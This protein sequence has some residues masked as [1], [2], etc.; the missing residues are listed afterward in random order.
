MIDNKNLP[1][2]NL[3]IELSILATCFIAGGEALSEVVDLVESEY[4][5]RKS[6]K[7]IFQAILDVAHNAESA[8]LATVVES[9]RSLGKLDEVGGVEAMSGILDNPIAVDIPY[10]C[11]KLEE[12]FLLRRAIEKCYST[13]KQCHNEY[14]DFDNIITKYVEHAH[15]ISDG[16]KAGDPVSTMK[17][18]S[19]RASDIYEKRYRDKKIVTGIPTGI[20][21]LDMKIF[22]LHEGDLTILAARPAMGKTAIAL[23]IAKHAAEE[24]YGSLFMSLEMPDTQLFDRLVAMETGING[25][26]IRI[27]N[28][29][30]K[31]FEMVNNATER[32]YNLPMFIDDRGGLKFTELVK[33]VRRMIKTN[34]E[35]KLLIIDHLQLLLGDN[36]TNRNLE[37]GTFSAGLKALAKELRIPVVALSQ[38]NRGLE[39]RSNPYRR[40]RLSDLRDSGSLEQ[41]ADNVIFIYRPWEYGDNI[42]PLDGKTEV[43][44]TETDCELIVAKQRQGPT[45]TVNCNF[46][47]DSQRVVG[48]SVQSPDE[49]YR[50]ELKKRE[51]GNDQDRKDI[52]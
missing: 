11:K 6:H 38:L 52:N 12:K 28:F 19:V 45:G 48:L 39:N 5:Y 41:D 31:E 18:I 15:E 17:E 25:M 30:V 3:E 50:Q 8:D 7:I 37:V 2:H 1:P 49:L 36:P 35:I 9:L 26:N 51:R 20:N 29:T 34:P 40:P 13:I 23:N 33:T 14:G 44:I 43:Q 27:G 32:L 46:Y 42:S 47:A 10:S 22:G 16:A 24:G 4:F 21:D